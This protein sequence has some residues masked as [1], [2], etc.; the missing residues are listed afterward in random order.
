MNLLG[1]LDSITSRRRGHP[2]IGESGRRGVDLCVVLGESE[3]PERVQL[4]DKRRDGDG[5][6][7]EFLFVRSGGL[8]V[9][10]RGE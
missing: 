7:N 9:Q 4:A 5:E 8:A 1:P 10:N 2:L 6:T 3:D